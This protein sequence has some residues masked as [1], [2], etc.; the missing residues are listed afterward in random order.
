MDVAEVLEAKL[1]ACAAYATQLGFQFGGE[2]SM[3]R[4]LAK[5]AS[6]E[7][8]RLCSPAPYAEALLVPERATQLGLVE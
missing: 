4:A 3:R 8:R 6:A 7:A 5:F 1:D 2:E